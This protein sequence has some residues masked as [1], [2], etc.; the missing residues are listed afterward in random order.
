[1]QL[2]ERIEQATEH[3]QQAQALLHGAEEDHPA[4]A[5]SIQKHLATAV[6]EL[7]DAREG[8]RPVAPQVQRQRIPE[9]TSGILGML[10]LL[11][12]QMNE[13]AR[14]LEPLRPSPEGDDS[15]DRLRGSSLRPVTESLGDLR[16][17]T[18]RM[19]AELRLL[20]ATWERP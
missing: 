3:I 15:V 11:L 20:R 19:E 12:H 8:D 10:S 13:T 16:R 1:M 14:Q 9:L 6:S 2:D 18:S 17:L 7:D 4:F 5:S